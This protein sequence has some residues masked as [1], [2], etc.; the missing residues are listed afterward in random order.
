MSIRYK[1]F[2]LKL[3]K[4]VTIISKDENLCVVKNKKGKRYINIK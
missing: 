1:I 4:I 3:M 2:N